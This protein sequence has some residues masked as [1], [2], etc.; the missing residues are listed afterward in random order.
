MTSGTNDQSEFATKNGSS[1]W[2]A[3]SPYLNEIQ[4]IPLL[5]G[6]EEKQL[7]R[8]VAQGDMEARDLLIR[9]NLRLVVN[10]A[11]HFVGR[12]LSVEDLIEEGN[13]GLMRAVESFDPEAT[14]RFSTYAVY[15]IR[16]SM[17]RAVI[18]QGKSLRFPA[19]LVNLMTKWNRAARLLS[20]QLGRQPS[21]D[22]VA[23]L[24]KLSR[25]KRDVVVWA[26][27]VLRALPSKQNGTNDDDSNMEDLIMDQRFAGVDELVHRKDCLERIFHSIHLLDEQEAEI[28][29]M[30]FGLSGDD[31]MGI[32]DTARRLCITRDRARYLEKKAIER[33]RTLSRGGRF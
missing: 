32:V 1:G 22:E 17:R 14:T 27:N 25:R 13:L 9:S 23:E 11:R 5:S 12:G 19:Y 10:T 33:L 31:A 4:K 24:M 3:I 6:R 21:D 20:E 15:W 26:L 2:S 18:N 8:R 16:Q 30:R 7:A 28:L 29:R